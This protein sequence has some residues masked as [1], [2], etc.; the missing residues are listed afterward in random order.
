MVRS[1]SPL[2]QALGPLAAQV[3]AIAAEVRGQRD[4]LAVVFPSLP[5]RLGREALRAGAIGWDGARVDL[6]A[7]RRCD[8]G[9][10]LLLA[11]VAAT[12][13]EVGAVYAHGDLEERTMLLRSLALLPIGPATV[14]LLAEVQRTNIIAHVEAAVCDSDLLARTVGTPGFAVGDANRLLLKIAFLDLPLHRVYAAER[15]ANVE[16]SRMLQ[17]L[18]TEREA[19]GRAVWRDTWRM[20]GRAPTAGSVARLVGGLEHGDDGVRLAAV[21]GLQSL[22]RP[23]LLPFARERLAREVRPAVREALQRLLH[24]AV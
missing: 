23:D 2:T 17:D 18:A 16:L 14:H 3:D 24:A 15:H 11:S 6:A 4:R 20:I 22:G 8:A 9:A 19:A 13:T 5:R 7:W 10:C 12:A 21:D 1:D